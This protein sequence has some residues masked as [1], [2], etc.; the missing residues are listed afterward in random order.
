MKSTKWIIGWFILVITVLL[1]IGCFVYK[2][3]P[4]FHYHK[5]DTK[6]YF[7]S[8]D[9]QRSQNDGISKHF[10]YDALITGTSMTENFK[11]SE[12]DEVFHVNS[13]KVAYSGGTYKE[14]ND[15]LSVA[16]KSNV[17]LKTVIR[18]LDYN[19]LIMDKD[20]MRSDLGKYPTYLYDHN[21][22]NDVYYLF[23]KD[24]IF[25]RA[26]EMTEETKREGFEP[27]ITSFDL[28][29]RW[30]Q[31]YTCGRKNVIP[32]GIHMGLTTESIHLNDEEKAIVHGNIT[33]N[34]TLLADTY[35]EVDFYYF[36]TPYSAAWWADLKNEGTI[37]RQI[38]AEEYAIELILKHENIKLFSFNNRTDITTDLNNY[39][40]SV[41]YAEWI[42]SLMLK[43]MH[44]GEYQ[45]TYDNYKEYLQRE[46][47][48]YTKFNYNSLDEQEDYEADYYAAALLNEE[49]TGT[50]PIQLLDESK[51]DIDALD[52]I[53]ISRGGL[54]EEQSNRT[55]LYEQ[56]VDNKYNCLEIRIDNISNYKYLCFK[57]KKVSDNGQPVVLIYNDKGEFLMEYT[58]SYLDLDNEWHQY[59]IDL[60]NLGEA[61]VIIFSGGYI[62]G[63][64]VNVPECQ[65]SDIALY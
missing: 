34:V 28:Y 7:Y 14:I 6:T 51:E 46:L 62:D 33:Q 52:K 32:E 2:I 42:N 20:A 5:P 41:H 11:T 50:K 15:N 39:R 43:A 12:M 48:F 59:L 4:Y 36:F 13:I 55:I 21:L 35:P 49:I 44:N 45:I 24:V 1:G 18:S 38:E 10:E 40:D 9:N 8:L 26:Y 22:F 53:V 64:E 29:S 63:S 47:E 58:K 25:S 61:V 65:F 54:P 60:N 23:N 30:Q 17:K 16:L 37:Y 56:L 19:L 3:D 27:G 31:W 57:G